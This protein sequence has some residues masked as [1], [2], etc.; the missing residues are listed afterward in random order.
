MKAAVNE[1]LSPAGGP[2]SENPSRVGTPI[3]GHPAHP[4]NGDIGV[5]TSAES[6]Q[7]TQRLILNFAPR[8]KL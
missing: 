7:V 5:A 4:T 8:G 1:G 2:G 6:T 3:H